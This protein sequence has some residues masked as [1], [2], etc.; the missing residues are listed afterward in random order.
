NQIIAFV[1]TVTTML[2]LWV[3]GFLAGEKT[4][5]LFQVMAYIGIQEHVN[6]FVKGVVDS[7]NMIYFLSTTIFC[8]FLTVRSLES[9][10]W[11]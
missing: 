5:P 6:D 4:E 8:L 3:I 2:V 11:R 7:R 1:I 10:K 9:R